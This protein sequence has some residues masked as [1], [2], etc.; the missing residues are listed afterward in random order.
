MSMQTS[1]TT[2]NVGKEVQSLVDSGY[3]EI[4]AQT[5]GNRWI[6]TADK[7]KFWGWLVTPTEME[8]IEEQVP[9]LE[10]L[11]EKYPDVS[12]SLR[13]LLRAIEGDREV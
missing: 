3:E 5:N 12:E 6:I 11:A 7:R 13:Y 8:A 10:R 2:K 4:L 9:K 1:A